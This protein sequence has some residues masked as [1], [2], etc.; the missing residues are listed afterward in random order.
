MLNQILLAIADKASE[1]ASLHF[2]DYGEPLQQTHLQ[3]Q[4]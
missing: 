3:Q 2:V 4:K 1:L